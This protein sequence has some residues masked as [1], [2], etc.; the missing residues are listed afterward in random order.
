MLQEALLHGVHIYQYTI[1]CML[2]C[3]TSGVLRLYCMQAATLK[4][5]GLRASI[6]LRHDRAASFGVC[7]VK[8]EVPIRNLGVGLFALATMAA[9]GF[10]LRRTRLDARVFRRRKKQLDVTRLYAAGM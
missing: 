10:F 9:A 1:L 4:V 8:Q 7:G 6:Y 2:R 5:K 3:G